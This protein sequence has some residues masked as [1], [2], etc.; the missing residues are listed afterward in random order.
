[1]PN[2]LI[3]VIIPTYNRLDHLRAAVRTV[4]GQTYRSLE[5]IVVDN[6]CTDGTDACVRRFVREDRRVR[7]VQE[8]T[9]GINPARNRGLSEAHGEWVAYLDDDELTPSHWLANLM[10]C[11]R[12]TGA[13]GAGGGYLAL[14]EGVPPKWLSRSECLKETVG[15]VKRGDERRPVEWLL[16]GNCLYRREALERVGGFGNYVG[17]RGRGSLA[18]GADVA[19]GHR[20]SAAGYRL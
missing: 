12:E 2:P 19:V 17:Y 15:V 13:D 7:H 3:T 14:W 5:L 1:M 8:D 20:L 9:Q 11:C 4:L 10:A 16:G 6:N 18:D